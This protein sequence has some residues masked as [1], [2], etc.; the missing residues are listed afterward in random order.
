MFIVIYYLLLPACSRGSHVSVA[1]TLKGTRKLFSTFNFVKYFFFCSLFHRLPMINRDQAIIEQNWTWNIQK[2]IEQLALEY[3]KI[4]N[5]FLLRTFQ[6]Y[7]KHSDLLRRI[8]CR[9][10]FRLCVPFINHK[11]FNF[12]RGFKN[13]IFLFT[14]IK[15]SVV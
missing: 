3:S 7:N 2:S 13:L 14:F 11:N 10:I 4:H 5:N 12:S 15:G 6:L 8:L 9:E 1:Q